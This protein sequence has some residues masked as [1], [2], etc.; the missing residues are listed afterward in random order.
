MTNAELATLPV[1]AV[2][3]LDD[4]RG[5]IRVAGR[6]VQIEWDWPET[7]S[8]IDTNAEVWQSLVVHF[9]AAT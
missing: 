3:Q 9:K 6:Q 5:T 1:G 7:T 4:E 2:I 8:L